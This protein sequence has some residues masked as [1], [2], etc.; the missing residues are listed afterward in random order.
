MFSNRY[1]LIY[2]AILVIIVAVALTIVAVML[3]P[4]Q[5][6]NI[7]VE[8]MQNILKSVNIES[9]AKNAEDLYNKYIKESFVITAKGEIQK[10]IKAFDVDLTLETKK[11]P[12]ERNLPVFVCTGDDGNPYYI[13]PVRGKGLWGPLWGYISFS[14][15]FNT[16]AG[17][18][19]D[20]KGE[21]PGLGAEINTSV[22][23]DQFIGKTIF[24]E[25]LNF[26]SI[27]VVKGGARPDD[28]HG[29]DAISG[30]TITSQGLE[31]MIYDGLSPYVTYFNKQME[32]K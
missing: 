11:K 8:K 22:F 5:T 28:N 29:V 16:I 19:F 12:D 32:K 31:K 25:Q 4:A 18:M 21:T 2:S 23:Q 30:G 26:V 10:D 17:T 6:N 7:R 15:D 1:T 13:I 9:D 14:N 3:K 27:H 20:H 24:D